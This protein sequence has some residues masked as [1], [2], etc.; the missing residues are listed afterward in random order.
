MQVSL[1]IFL[2]NLWIC[3]LLTRFETVE[4]QIFNQQINKSKQAARCDKQH[5]MSFVYSVCDIAR[6]HT[7]RIQKKT[8]LRKS[9]KKK[10]EMI[11][12]LIQLRQQL[13]KVL[14]SNTIRD[15][16]HLRKR[17]SDTETFVMWLKLIFLNCISALAR[18]LILQLLIFYVIIFIRQK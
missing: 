8:F 13:N 12:C 18:V 15:F 11:Q 5:K 17:L 2:S 1:L 7:I 4:G 10:S 3:V 14:A 16:L 6:S 9:Q